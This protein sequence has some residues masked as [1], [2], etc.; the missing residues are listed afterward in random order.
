MIREA[1]STYSKLTERFRS[2]PNVVFKLPATKAGLEAAKELTN[3]GIGV[4]ITVSFGLFQALP[5]AENINNGQAIVS[6]LVVMNGRLANPVIDE[7]K[8][9]GEDFAQAGRW[10]GVAVSKRLYQKLYAPIDKGGQGYDSKKIR[11]IVASLRNYEGSFPDI[12]ELV[13]VPIITVFPNI[14]RDFDSEGVEIN[15]M[16][17]EKPVDDKILEKLFK[18]ELFKQAYYATDDNDEMRPSSPFSLNDEEKVLEY[19]PVRN[20]LGQFCEYRI[21]MREFVRCRLS[22]LCG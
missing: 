14:R 16:Q 22:T 19:P 15:P 6:Y 11:I 12:T 21:K 4:T 3:R 20:T 10:A 9:I 13:G 2:V 17:I 8:K 1:L 18:S 5:F 7:L